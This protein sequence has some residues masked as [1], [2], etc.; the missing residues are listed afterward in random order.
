M[1][2][3]Q[4]VNQILSLVSRETEVSEVR[5]IAGSKCVDVVDARSICVK[6]M[7]ENGF[8]PKQIAEHLHISA[9]AVRNLLTSYQERV[10]SNKI[11]ATY[12]QNVRSAL[13]T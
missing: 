5:I 11:I 3:T 1:C 8:Y 10:K 2:K 9:S 12:A 6:I 7:T 4:I 13:K